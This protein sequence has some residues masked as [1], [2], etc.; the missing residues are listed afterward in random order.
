MSKK[1][2][3]LSN[4]TLVFDSSTIYVN[5]CISL[6]NTSLTVDLS[7][8]NNITNQE[9]LVL[10]NS[11]MGCLNGSSYTIHY[12]NQPKCYS[13]L[14]EKDDNSIFLIFSKNNCNEESQKQ[15]TFQSWEIAV[16]I[17]G[18]VVVLAIIFVLLALFS[19]LRRKIF[20]HQLEK[21]EDDKNPNPLDTVQLKMDDLQS[22][23][24]NLKEQEERVRNLLENN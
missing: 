18:S 9:K 14:S 2:L 11:S 24:K 22:E 5:G 16:I 17:V 23:I 15:N 19:P 7:N 4:S 8:L 13:I 1:N 21:K 6:L 10:L 20:P 3:S 12:L